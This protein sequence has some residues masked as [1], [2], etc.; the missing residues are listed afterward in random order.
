MKKRRKKMDF[1]EEQLKAIN[2]PLDKHVLVSASAGS[3]KTQI[4]S[5]KV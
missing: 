1:N 3:G 4:L 2:S 5:Q